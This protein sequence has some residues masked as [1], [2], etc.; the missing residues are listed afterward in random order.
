MNNLKLRLGK[1]IFVYI[2]VGI[3]AVIIG[4]VLT[5]LMN[6]VCLQWMHIIIASCFAIQGAAIALA[7]KNFEI[8]GLPEDDRDVKYA[9]VNDSI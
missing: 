5:A 1:G 7:V 2:S 4:G 8:I 6:W 9:T 3:T